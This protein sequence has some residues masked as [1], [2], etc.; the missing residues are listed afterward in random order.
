MRSSTLVKLTLLVV[1]MT[2]FPTIAQGIVF[3]RPKT[4]ILKEKVLQNSQVTVKLTGNGGVYLPPK[5]STEKWGGFPDTKPATPSKPAV[6][7][8]PTHVKDNN[9]PIPGIH[10]V[11]DVDQI[12]TVD[13]RQPRTLLDADGEILS[14]GGE[15]SDLSIEALVF[16]ATLGQYQLFNIFGV[17]EQ[18]VGYKEVYIPDLFADTNGDGSL[19]DGD[20]LYSLVDLVSYLPA[21]PSVDLGKSYTIVNG[22]VPELP[23]MLFSTTPFTFDAITGFSWSPLDGQGI[24]EGLHGV[25]ATPEPSTILLLGSGMAG[26]AWFGRRKWGRQ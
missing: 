25:A 14:A 9:T 10:R 1:F 15:V 21:L 4:G 18:F 16:D 20:V 2:S 12:I 19:G 17:I 11:K 8:I 6:F 13:P 22:Q 26:L 23:G 7:K 3:D 5:G 24:T